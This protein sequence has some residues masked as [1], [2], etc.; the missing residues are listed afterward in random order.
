MLL[1]IDLGG[2]VL[3]SSLFLIKVLLSDSWLPSG[4]NEEVFSMYVCV[5]LSRS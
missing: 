2:A 1:L 3:Y 4:D 5:Q